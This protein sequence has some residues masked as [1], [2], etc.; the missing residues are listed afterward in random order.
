MYRFIP[1]LV[2]CLLAGVQI[3]D[4]AESLAVYSNVCLNKDS[5]DLNGIRI[6]ILRMGDAPY[7]VMQEPGGILFE[8][9]EMKKLSPDDLRKGEINFSFEYAQ[10]PAP[11]KGRITKNAIVG[12]FD[13]KLLV[14]DYGWKIIQL[15]RVSPS[16]K[17]YD[18]CR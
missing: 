13:N 3:A 17:T 11:F 15:H 1:V 14:K 7:F 18:V 4:A 9:S 10:K 5:G 2:L 8:E 12:T 6:I 16:K